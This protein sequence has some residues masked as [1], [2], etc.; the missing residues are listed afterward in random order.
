MCYYFVA[1]TLA[2]Y[3]TIYLKLYCTRTSYLLTVSKAFNFFFFFFFILLFWFIYFF[4]VTINCRDHHHHQLLFFTKFYIFFTNISHCEKLGGCNSKKLLQCRSRCDEEEE[5][6]SIISIISVTSRSL[7]CILTSIK[8]LLNDDIF[9]WLRMN[10]LEG[11]FKF[12]LK[13]DS[14]GSKKSRL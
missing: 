6:N 5:D 3:E 13:K 2:C 1:L 9:W 14:D 8:S 7:L 10:E 11:I 12:Y 4:I